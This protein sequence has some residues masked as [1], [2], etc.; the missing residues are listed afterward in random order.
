MELDFET[1]YRAVSSRDARFDGWFITGVT[2]TG[3]Y[4]RPSC[5]ATTPK[6][7]NVR[8]FPTAAAAHAAGLRACKRCLPDASPGSPEW[9]VRG[10]VVARA[11]RLISDGVVDRDGVAEL[12]GRL[13]FSERHI[14]RLLVEELGAGPQAIARAQR[15]QTART[16]I[17][18]TTLRFAEIAFAA[19]FNSIR[20]FNDTMKE[21]Y[22][23]TP[24]ELRRKIK[25]GAPDVGG[26]IT[27][28]LAFRKPFDGVSVLTFLGAR[29]VPGVEE[30]G[31]GVYRR[32]LDLPHSAGIVELTPAT[33]QVDCMLRLGDVRDLQAAVQRCRAL[34]D[35]DADPVAV[36]DTLRRDP[37]LRSSVRRNPGR[38]VPG[39]VDGAE[40]AFRAVLGQQVSVKG[41]RTLAGR[42]VDQLGKPLTNPDGGLTHVFPRPDAIA[43]ADLTKIGMPVSRQRT[44]RS[45][46]SAL[47]SGD[48]VLDRGADRDEMRARLPE[49]PGIGP[50]TT[51]YIAM[52]ALGDPDVF[53]PTDLGVKHALAGLD[54]ADD[55]SDVAERWRPWRAYAVQHLW[56]ILGEKEA[57]R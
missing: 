41:A 9:N 6:R 19:G 52:R 40:L 57:N 30:F 7:A 49:I 5:P 24:T 16:L 54:V 17:E 21:V 32:T 14:H 28:K 36:D 47:A 34:L 37:L 11:M 44:L 38:R 35:L 18:R 13:H 8:F 43:D 27:L 1:C 46:A 53:L 15:A 55:P 4:C 31:S 2:S 48:V 39:V 42:L 51:S 23:H 33:D 20:Q 25:T 29:A 56:A 45:L 12:A 22:A 50:W 26:A 10:D 3:I